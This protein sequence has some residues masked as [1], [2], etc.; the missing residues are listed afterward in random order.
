VQLPVR[1]PGDVPRALVQLTAI[2]A[3]HKVVSYR[4]RGK[5]AV[6]NV[7]TTRVGAGRIDGARGGV[8]RPP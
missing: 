2:L 7:L 1:T 4:R 3:E 5:I 8:N 6:G